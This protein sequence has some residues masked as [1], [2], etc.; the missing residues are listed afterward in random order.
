MP[1]GKSLKEEPKKVEQS[2]VKEEVKKSEEKGNEFK[3][4]EIDDDSSIEIIEVR[5]P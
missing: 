5:R 3:K 4:I 2:I 1:E